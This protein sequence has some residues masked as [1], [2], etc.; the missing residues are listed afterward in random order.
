[1]IDLEAT[2][3]D[4]GK[5]TRE[6]CEII[7]IG[8]VMIESAFIARE[9]QSFVRP[10]TNPLLTDFCKNLTTITQEQVDEAEPFNVVYQRFAEWIG[11]E[12]TIM[13]SWGNW[14]REQL[15]KEC[16]LAGFTFPFQSNISLPNALMKFC[17]KSN[18]W[19]VMRKFD[20]A[21]EGVQHRG[22]DDARNYA[23]I[24]EKMIERGWKP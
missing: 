9:F 4:D 10:I 3:S 21:Y 14:D 11:S 24:V 22:I 5:I 17:G 2:C 1:M 19:R 7:E 16:A 23:R 8:A 20:I 6:Q 12:E 18:K 13:A 15:M